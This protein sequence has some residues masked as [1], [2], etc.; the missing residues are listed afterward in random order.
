MAMRFTLSQEPV[1]TAMPPGFLDLFYKA[2]PVGESYHKITE[3]ETQK[4]QEMAKSAPSVFRRGEER[5]ALDTSSNE[6]LYADSPHEC[7]PYS[8]A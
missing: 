5:L 4:L 7:C 8:N 1:T 2:I 3:A 6:P